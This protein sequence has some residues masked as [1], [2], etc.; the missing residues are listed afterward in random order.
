MWNGSIGGNGLSLATLPRNA[1]ITTISPTMS[2][3]E[4][5]MIANIYRL[6]FRECYK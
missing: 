6:H 4:R 2:F 1:G 3:G 5:V